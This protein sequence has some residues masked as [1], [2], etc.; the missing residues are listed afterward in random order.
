MSLSLP[1]WL[2]HLFKSYLLTYVIPPTS[3]STSYLQT[4]SDSLSDHLKLHIVHSSYFNALLH[5]L[6]KPPGLQQRMLPSHFPTFP[7]RAGHTGGAQQWAKG[8]QTLP[9]SSWTPP[10]PSFCLHPR[11]SQDPTCHLS[12]SG[13]SLIK[14]CDLLK[15][16][17]SDVRSK[18]KGLAGIW[19][20][21]LGESSFML[22]NSQHYWAQTCELINWF[23]FGP[24]T[25][26]FLGDRQVGRISCAL[27]PRAVAACS[28]PL[29]QAECWALRRYVITYGNAQLASLPQTICLSRMVRLAV[30]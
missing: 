9:S 25:E 17:G 30:C 1:R 15:S 7:P 19:E 10:S 28:W 13:K 21:K 24:F 20:S 11:T 14:R 27:R 2:G 5:G 22:N 12:K 6:H 4:F 29:N 16:K 26:L 18:L 3:C 23:V 8:T